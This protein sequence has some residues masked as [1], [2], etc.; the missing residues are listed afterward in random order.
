M[1]IF[2]LHRMKDSPRQHF[3]WAPHSSGASVVKPRD[4]EFSAEFEAASPYALWETLRG[5]DL[6]LRLG[7]VLELQDGSLKIYKYVGFEAAT[8]FLA[9]STSDLVLTAQ[10][11]SGNPNQPL[12]S[13]L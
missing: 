7:D 12:G 9:D 6:A 10:S 2:R 1:A 5:T 13:S 8:W 11:T 3:R 4:F